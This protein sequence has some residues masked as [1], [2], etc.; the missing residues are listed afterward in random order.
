MLDEKGFFD[1]NEATLRMFGLSDRSELL[2][3]HPWELSPPYQPDG[4]DS[5]TAAHRRDAEAFEK[6]SS[7][8]EW[9][10]RRRNG[11]DFPAD[12]LLTAFHL[13]DHKVLQATVRDIT[14]R[15]QAE[16][17]LRMLS[18]AVEQSPASVVI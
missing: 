17:A 10:H 9:M 5:V 8:F 14:E 13:G 2:S 6:G 4:T 11:E 18:R 3:V 16:E 12:V 1:C 7:H 15:K